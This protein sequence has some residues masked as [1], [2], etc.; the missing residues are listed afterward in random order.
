MARERKQSTT[1]VAA[2]E[3]LVGFSKAEQM[4]VTTTI[5]ADFE[6][7]R[8][9]EE[10]VV[11]ADETY[12]QRCVTYPPD[13]TTRVCTR[14]PCLSA[15]DA[16]LTAAGKYTPTAGLGMSSLVGYSKT[17]EM[18]ATT[19]IVA[20]YG[21]TTVSFVQVQAGPI[22]YCEKCVRKGDTT[23]CTTIECPPPKKPPTTPM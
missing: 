10:R 9:T 12:C 8:I 20:Q 5:V 19:T 17:Q 6:D 14:I 4:T 13:Y 2:S 21:D 15:S 22:I 7:A 16:E 1:T 23:T 11:A 3:S 18:S